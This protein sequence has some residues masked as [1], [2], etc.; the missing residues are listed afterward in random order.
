MVDHRVNKGKNKNLLRKS[1]RMLTRA[2]RGNN[3]N[4]VLADLFFVLCRGC[5][6]V[7]AN[8]IL[9][10]YFPL[11]SPLPSL[12]VAGWRRKRRG[13]GR[14]EIHGGWH[15]RED[16]RGIQ[17]H[18]ATEPLVSLSLFFYSP[19]LVSSPSLLVFLSPPPLHFSRLFIP[20][21]LR[22]V[23]VSPRSTIIDAD[24]SR[25]SSPFPCFE[26]ASRNRH[27]SSLH[28]VAHRSLSLSLS[29]DHRLIKERTNYFFSRVPP[30]KNDSILKT[31]RVYTYTMRRVLNENVN[32]NSPFFHLRCEEE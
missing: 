23:R 15:L 29:L 26:V 32:S 19:L 12:F 9:F 16:Q 4:S 28:A 25:L 20:S 14:A 27:P 31:F 7:Y 30:T 1:K 5:F 18:P 11:F 13:C 21:R 6:V 17:F 22:R 10:S 2:C 8:R 3:H 24:A